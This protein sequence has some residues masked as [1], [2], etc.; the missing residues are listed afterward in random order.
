MT[1][2][3][4]GSVS[5]SCEDLVQAVLSLHGFLNNTAYSGTLICPF[6]NKSLPCLHGFFQSLKKQHKAEDPL[7]KIDHKSAQRQSKRHWPR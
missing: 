5:S 7:Y 1:K 4:L 3:V 6:S 2:G